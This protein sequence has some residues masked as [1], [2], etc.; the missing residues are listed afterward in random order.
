VLIESL[1]E[2]VEHLLLLLLRLLVGSTTFTVRLNLPFKFRS[3]CVC[4]TDQGKA[5]H[6]YQTSLFDSSLSL[7]CG[8]FSHLNHS[9]LKLLTNPY[10]H[11]T[12]PPS[13]PHRLSY[14]LLSDQLFAWAG[15][16]PFLSEIHLNFSF[17]MATF[18]TKLLL[19]REK[20]GRL[21]CLNGTCFARSDWAVRGRWAT[22]TSCHS[23]QRIN[24]T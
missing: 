12:P 16:L 2:P 6:R 24:P 1:F 5:T 11:F 15:N 8:S 10:F 4:L 19:N 14:R 9:L 17:Q 7:L 22:F 13:F 23:D 21:G 3:N 18:C 20:K